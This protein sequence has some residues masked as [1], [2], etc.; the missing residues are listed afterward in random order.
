MATEAASASS[1]PGRQATAATPQEPPAAEASV[2]AQ[3]SQAASS[4]QQSSLPGAG[5]A[6]VAVPAAGEQ[7]EEDKTVEELWGDANQAFG[8]LFPMQP[9]RDVLWGLYNGVK[10][11]LSGVFIGL[12]TAFAQPIQGTTEAGLWGCFRGVGTGLLGAVFFSA[13]GVCAGAFQAIRGIFATPRAICMA[14]RGWEWDRNTGR[15]GEPAI[16]SLPE[17]AARVLAEDVPDGAT[18]GGGLGLGQDTAGG[19]SSSSSRTVADTYYYDQL[20]VPASASERDIRKAYFTLSKRWHPD[21]TDEE[22]AKERFQAISEAY[23]VLSDPQRRQSYDAH[24][25]KGDSEDFIDSRMFFSV[26]FSGDVLEPLIGQLI[27]AD[28][29]NLASYQATDDPN[30]AGNKQR[31]AEK[32]QVEQVR[33]QVKLAVDLVARLEPYVQGDREAQT[34]VIEQARKE[35]QGMLKRDAYVIVGRFLQEVGWMYKNRAECYLAKIDSCLGRWGYQAVRMRLSG[36]SREAGQKITTAGLAV[37][38]FI[39][40]RNLAQAEGEDNAADEDAI[41]DAVPTFM[42]T[43]FS[44]T[45][46][47]ISSTLDKVI[48]RVLSDGSVPLMS[49]RLRALGMRELGIVFEE[50]ATRQLATAAAASGPDAGSATA[51]LQRFEQAFRASV[52]EVPNTQSDE[53]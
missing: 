23:Q 43:F 51:Q 1:A 46:H 10:C 27:V 7:P 29:F 18:A 4:V 39:K 2:P 35:A 50:E 3:P 16:Y 33:R 5:H 15:W 32:S 53:G 12:I 25:R 49:L 48:H 40:L 6:L 52:G 26:L 37:K 42:E 38:S 44:F 24:G 11:V 22:G 21:K 9:P 13:T 34:A 41:W 36:S 19:A 17:E 47:D 8:E 28:L 20:G 14:S 30:A 31:E 45:A